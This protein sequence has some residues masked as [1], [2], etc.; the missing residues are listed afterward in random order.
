MLNHR[1]P[2][3]R[4]AIAIPAHD[5]EA[6]IEATVQRLRALDYPTGLFGIRVVADHCSDDT[7]ALA[8]RAGA[9]VYER[10]EGPRS[11]KGAALNWLFS[12]ILARDDCDAIVVFDSDTQVDSMF[13]QVMDARL[14]QGEQAVQGQ[15]IISNAENG[16]FPALT[17]AMFLVDNRYGNLGRTNLGWS[18]KHMGDSICFCA[19]VL[20]SVGGGEGLTE[21]YQLRQQLL[22]Q[23]IKIAYEPAAI[24]YGEAP[25]TWAQAQA[26][27]ARW[28]RGTHDASQQYAKCLLKAAIER[29]DGAILDGA[30]QAYLPSYSTLTMAG[31]FCLLVQLCINWLTGPVFSQ[32]VIWVWAMAAA[33]LF[34]YPFLGLALEN[35]PLRAYAAILSGPFYIV[36]RTWLALKARLFRKDVTWVRTTHGEQ[37]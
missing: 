6:V 10:D 32:M 5:E 9:I 16:W 21:D 23:N 26:Q 8:R 14:A 33:T 22:L 4:F 29:R 1:R 3:I 25:R 37:S 13:L 36:W 7:A 15:H 30:L 35:A 27:R 20:R 34:F 12:H 31:V 19:E 2:S 28:L 17:W 18:A 11:G 24:G